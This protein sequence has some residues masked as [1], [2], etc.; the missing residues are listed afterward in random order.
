MSAPGQAIAAEDW[1]ALAR[2]VAEAVAL[3]A[4][5]HVRGAEIA[6]DGLQRLPV[7]LAEA[8]RQRRDLL[9]AFIG[10]GRQDV[11][12]RRFFSSLGVG[13]KVVTDPAHVPGALAELDADARRTGGVVSL[14][15][16]TCARPEYATE[17]VYLTFN[18]D[19][20][21]SATQPK[22]TDGT[23]LDPHRARVALMQLYA[24]GAEVFVIHGE[25]AIAALLS[26]AWLRRV[27]LICHHAQFELSFLQEWAEHQAV[28]EAG[29]ARRGVVHDT[30]QA[31]GLLFGVTGGRS[32]ARAATVVLG[33]QPPKDLQTS[34]WAAPKLSRGQLCYAAADAIV[35]WRLWNRLQR[36]LAKHGRWDAYRLQVGACGPVAA[37]QRRGIL[38]DRDEHARRV[39]HWTEEL[40]GS[41]ER[42][43]AAT[44]EPA[45]ETP[46][47]LGQWLER[48]LPPHVVQRWPR[49]PASNALAT[50]SKFLKHIASIPSV[51]PVLDILG[52]KKLLQSFGPRLLEHIN[53]A[54]GRLH[55]AFNISGAKSG[56]FTCARPNLQQLPS[57][58]APE[59]R[60]CVV[61]AEG[62]LL[63]GGDWSQV[64]LR[65]AA[66][67][68]KDPELTRV[69]A[70]G[71]D[72]HAETAATITGV[73]VSQVTREMRQ[74]AKATNFGA[75][76]GIGA[77]SL[78]QNAFAAYGVTMS[79]QEAQNALDRFFAR[80]AVLHRFLETHAQQCQHKGLIRI[81]AGRVV[82]AEWELQAGGLTYPK[83]CNLP[84]QGIAA[85]AMLRGVVLAAA[86]LRTHGVR[87][88]LIATVH[89]EL[90][91]EVPEDQANIAKGILSGAM[92]D[93]FV[94]TFPGAPTGNLVD[95]AIGPTWA[96][97]K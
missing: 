25:A 41:R 97:L 15:I 31:F 45:P 11:L 75:L 52:R 22:D 8:L 14:D 84:V 51:Q 93:A 17:P 74:R 33:I 95:A 83:C 77:P 16:E 3:G 86:R 5:F 10:A 23:A 54:T 81:G 79:V 19:G 48:I 73:P 56:R 82:L 30:L 92:T 76:Y 53:P 2:L 65:A 68:S 39:A 32:L 34:T 96:S 70:H 69:Y 44:G 18:R 36:D 64:E 20:A 1:Q 27:S 6:V 28:E 7:A 12:A 21:L 67:L 57:A 94:Q 80:F 71:L 61:A 26:S 43:T 29:N 72:L 40:T 87:G 91:A 60:R 50:G 47:A 63:V 4:K 66:W 42:Y 9:W 62:N 55:P 37:M 88:G 85:D 78:A 59:F 35:T 89:D 13:L 24:G 49:T 46:T 58:K 90:L 38:L